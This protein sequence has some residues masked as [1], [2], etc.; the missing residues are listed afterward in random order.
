MVA[1]LTDVIT[2]HL[3]IDGVARPRGSVQVFCVSERK[4][5]L[6]QDSDLISSF[7]IRF[8]RHHG[9]MTNRVESKILP[10]LQVVFPKTFARRRKQFA[11]KIKIVPVASQIKWTPVQDKPAVF[12][13]QPPQ[14]ERDFALIE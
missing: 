6:N 1:H 11:R 14:T 12:D 10:L 2:P 13:L 7:Q 3:L 4:F 5:G 9:M 8:G